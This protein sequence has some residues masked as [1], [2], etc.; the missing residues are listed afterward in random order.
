MSILIQIDRT[1]DTPI[2]RQIVDRLVALADS[3]AIQP[4]VRLPSTRSMADML[5]VDRSTVYRAY[6]ELWALGYVES[7]PGSYTTIR[8]RTRIAK[9][10]E[11]TGSRLIDWEER[12]SPCARSL[13]ASFLEDGERMKRAAAADVINFMPLSP[14]SRLIPSELFRKCMN[15]VLCRRGPEL[16]QYGNPLGYEPL[17]AFIAERMREHGVSVSVGEIMIASGAQNALELLLRML[18]GPGD[19]VIVESPTYSRV[20]DLL[21]LSDIRIV[22]VPMKED[23][24]DLD[25][26]EERLHRERPAFI[27]TMPNFHNPTGITTEQGHRERLLRLCET[28]RTPLIED[29]FEEELKYFGKAVLPVKSM[30]RRGGVIYVG[31]FSKCLFPG[32]RIG[33][34]A[35]DG[36]CIERLAPIQR[37]L[38][39]SGNALDQAAVHRFCRAGYYDLHIKRV[40]R[41]Y[42]KRMRTALDAM[43][44]CLNPNQ[45]RW[46]QPA[47][48]YTIWLQLL[49]G[50]WD[51]DDAVDRLFRH[52]VA[53]TPGRPHFPGPSGAAHLRV[54]IA[55]TDEASIREGI[56]RM[57]AALS[58]IP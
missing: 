43:K 12:I 51:E 22:D 9:K 20:I 57:G 15:D 55:H 41:V 28:C 17:R 53:V 39:I 49:S 6:Q 18:A 21:R 58:E 25:A 27:Y 32:L 29:G 56:R 19:S 13:Q 35:A 47:G 23:G 10:Q 1:S 34:I 42:R 26:L 31:T 48:G 45:V 2:F 36:A 40:H 30:D 50:R 7:R 4:G 3:A 37:A 24:M 14:D 5:S 38:V 44:S 33:W 46:T 8:S 54:S 16:L 11:R 52:G